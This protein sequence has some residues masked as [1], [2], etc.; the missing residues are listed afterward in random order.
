MGSTYLA[1]RNQTSLQETEVEEIPEEIIEDE[2]VIEIKPD[3]GIWVQVSE[4][5]YVPSSIYDPAIDGKQ[6]LN[7]PK[8]PP[9]P[10]PDGSYIEN[11]W[12]NK[13]TPVTLPKPDVFR[14]KFSVWGKLK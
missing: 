14:D 3:T 6:W 13:P 7:V 8:C 5:H 11:F 2:E 10:A 1:H 4:R 12:A 9:P